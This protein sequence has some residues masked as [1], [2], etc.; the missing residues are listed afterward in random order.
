M[1]CSQTEHRKGFHVGL[2]DAAHYSTASEPAA[3]EGG[4]G[5]VI[6]DKVIDPPNTDKL[7]GSVDDV[8]QVIRAR[9]PLSAVF[10]EGFQG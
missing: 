2:R 3:Q 10:E 1:D 4:A 5:E 6:I 9:S 7:T 8:D